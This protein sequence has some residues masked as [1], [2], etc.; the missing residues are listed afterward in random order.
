MTG[1]PDKQKIGA[2]C[3]R[4][5]S[6]SAKRAMCLGRGVAAHF[7]R[8]RA[9]K[10]AE[11]TTAKELL[12]GEGFGGLARLTCHVSVQLKAGRALEP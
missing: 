12:V 4:H 1:P 3:I 2:T 9:T 10:S 7:E 5:V 11:T 6:G 8:D